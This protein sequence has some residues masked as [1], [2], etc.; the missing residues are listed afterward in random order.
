VQ[1]ERLLIVFVKAPRVG[2]VKT[3]LAQEIGAERA[4]EAYQKLVRTVLGKIGSLVNVQLRYSPDDAESEVQPWRKSSWTAAA[5]GAGDLGERLARGF[6]DAFKSGASRVAIIGSDCPWLDV[7][8]IE[9]A[10]S[11]VETHDVVL[12]PARD[13]G[14]WLIGLRRPLPELFTGIAWSTPHVLMQ[15]L[16]RARPRDLRVRLLREL[17]DVDTLEDWEVFSRDNSFA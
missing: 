15:T 14:Y 7:A 13:G 16:E 10:W 11:E 1:S 17:R 9:E 2:A 8:D 4:C 12:G 3:R 6:S 5:Q